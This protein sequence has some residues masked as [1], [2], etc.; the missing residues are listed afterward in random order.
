MSPRFVDPPASMFRR[1]PL[2]DPGLIAL[3]GAI[4]ALV[5]IFLAI[6]MLEDGLGVRLADVLHFAFGR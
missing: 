1:R 2:V 4:V 3:G 6:A 5:F